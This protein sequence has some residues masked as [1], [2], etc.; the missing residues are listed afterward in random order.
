MVLFAGFGRV[1]GVIEIARSYFFTLVVCDLEFKV[2]VFGF[3]GKV[4]IVF[5]RMSL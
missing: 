1:V 4:F 5:F 3:F 2:E